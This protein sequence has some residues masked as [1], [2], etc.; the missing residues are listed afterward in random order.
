MNVN[1]SKSKPLPLYLLTLDE[2]REALNAAKAKLSEEDQAEIDQ[3]I[4]KLIA[5]IKA[6]HPGMQFS[7]DGALET[8]AAIGIHY[9]KRTETSLK[10]KGE[11]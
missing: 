7:P 2:R 5:A 8:I 6:K 10:K 11:L 4:S 3:M 1:P 9:F